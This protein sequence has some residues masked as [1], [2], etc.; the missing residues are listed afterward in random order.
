M[1][2]TNLIINDKPVLP[3]A[4]CH[5]D[6][7]IEQ[8]AGVGYFNRLNNIVLLPASF[9]AAIG[10]YLLQRGW[11]AGDNVFELVTAFMRQVQ[12]QSEHPGLAEF[13]SADN[14]LISSLSYGLK[15]RGYT[16]PTLQLLGPAAT[17]YLIYP[18]IA[19]LL[20]HDIPQSEPRELTLNLARLLAGCCEEPFERGEKSAAAANLTWQ[21][22]QGENN[23]VSQ[24]AGYELSLGLPATRPLFG[25]NT[26]QQLYRLPEF[27]SAVFIADPQDSAMAFCPALTTDNTTQI[28]GNRSSTA[29]YLRVEAQQNRVIYAISTT[30]NALS[31]NTDP[32]SVPAVALP[33]S[34]PNDVL[35]F[36]EKALTIPQAKISLW[37]SVLR[38]PLRFPEVASTILEEDIPPWSA[39]GPR[40]VIHDGALA[41]IMHRDS[42]KPVGRPDSNLN[43][44]LF[45]PSSLSAEEELYQMNVLDSEGLPYPLFAPA[46]SAIDC[47]DCLPAPAEPVS[48]S[49]MQEMIGK[50]F[51]WVNELG[52]KKKMQVIEQ[53]MHAKRLFNPQENAEV[54]RTELENIAAASEWL[55]SCDAMSNTLSILGAEA[56]IFLSKLFVAS[57]FDQ[58]EEL[59]KALIASSVAEVMLAK[60]LLTLLDRHLPSTKQLLKTSNQHMTVLMNQAHS[61]TYGQLDGFLTMLQDS[62]ISR[63]SQSLRGRFSTLPD[64]I[65][66]HRM[67]GMA[68]WHQRMIEFDYPF[69]LLRHKLE[70]RNETCLSPQGLLIDMGIRRVANRDNIASVSRKK[71]IELG[72]DLLLH[73]SADSLVGD[74]NHLEG[75]FLA[76]EGNDG[77][78]IRYTADHLKR[79]GVL[80][81]RFIAARRQLSALVKLSASHDA[82]NAK[83]FKDFCLIKQ[84]L[85]ALAFESLLRSKQQALLLNLQGING[86]ELQFVRLS[87]TEN[88]AGQTRPYIGFLLSS[89]GYA[90]NESAPPVMENYFI[91]LVPVQNDN[92]QP[93][94][95]SLDADLP[96]SLAERETV[97]NGKRKAEMLGRLSETMLANPSRYQFHLLNGGNLH[98]SKESVLW[99][100][101]VNSLAREIVRRQFEAI[102]PAEIQ[103]STTPINLPQKT[104]QQ[105]SSWFHNL[106][107]QLIYLT[108]L[109]SCKDAINDI[110]QGHLAPLILDAA[111]CFYAFAPGG[112][113]EEEAVKSVANVIKKVLKSALDDRKIVTEGERVLSHLD[114]SIVEAEQQLE[115]R[116]EKQRPVHYHYTPNVDLSALLTVAKQ[117][118]AIPLKKLPKDYQIVTA[119]RDPL[120]DVFYFT[121]THNSEE[122]L[123]YRLDEKNQLLM[124]NL[125]GFLLAWGQSEEHIS[126]LELLKSCLESGN[127]QPLRLKI[128]KQERIGQLMKYAFESRS[129][130]NSIFTALT[131]SIKDGVVYYPGIKQEE[132]EALYLVAPAGLP[133]DQ[134]LVV[135]ARN[136]G[137]HF[138]KDNVIS[139]KPEISTGIITQ[140]TDAYDTLLNSLTNI[141]TGWT[142]K[143]L[144]IEENSADRIVVS[145]ED[146]QGKTHYR[147]PDSQGKWLFWDSKHRDIFCQVLSRPKR[148]DP[149]NSDLVTEIFSPAQC[150]YLL[151]P[152]VD[153]EERAEAL[154]QL[155]TTFMSLANPVVLDKIDCSALAQKIYAE[156]NPI[157]ET[158]PKIIRDFIINVR[159]WNINVRVFNIFEVITRALLDYSNGIIISE[160]LNED[161]KSLRSRFVAHVQNLIEE[162]G[163]LKKAVITSKLLLEEFKAVK[164]QYLEAYIYRNLKANNW[165]NRRFAGEL[166]SG[167]IKGDYKIK[168][169]T[170]A[171]IRRD[172][173]FLHENV[174]AALSRLKEMSS[175][176]ASQLNST[177]SVDFLTSGL[178]QFF[179]AGFTPVQIENFK[180][181]LQ[182][183]LTKLSSFNISDI[184]V[185]A[186]RIAEG[187]LISGCFK[188]PLEKLVFGDGAYSF[189]YNSDNDKRIYLLDYLTDQKFLEFSLAH[190][191]VHLTYED[192]DYVFQEEIYLLSESILKNFNMPGA[193]KFAGQLMSNK[194]FF[195]DY[196]SRN[197]KYATAFYLHFYAQSR[198]HIHKKELLRHQEYF[199]GRESIISIGNEPR[200]LIKKRLAPLVDYLF[201]EPYIKLNMAYYNP[202]L[203]CGLFNAIY[204]NA[205]GTTQHTASG[206][207]RRETNQYHGKFVSSYM[208]LLFSALY[209]KHL[210]HPD[211]GLAVE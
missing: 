159:D 24:P 116:L 33:S 105:P 64:F 133:E 20:H 29:F 184:V 195:L 97:I 16:L 2:L 37:S 53:F 58:N 167:K 118:K 156:F 132:G 77:R 202:D 50:A 94:I 36:P 25:P 201:S 188:T 115:A 103:Q 43:A 9:T 49:S 55:T 165:L 41:L 147:H 210:M 211:A 157:W 143:N 107:N 148:N 15:Q 93:L 151:V 204:E 61:V 3:V 153:S 80:L 8:A 72:H 48:A 142:M 125:S 100:Q 38:D 140:A 134:Q 76:A 182:L 208:S 87:D 144:W 205:I 169:A 117:F 126:D 203:F 73:N 69:M 26:S 179:N 141:P 114:S 89:A 166:R 209:H 108:P 186:D 104:S 112:S 44:Q 71:L 12:T 150:G 46:D 35:R 1:P 109:G 57:P 7:L 82:S 11:Q 185:V 154:E 10:S 146:S 176:I 74:F 131:V 47:L 178:N 79:Q 152:R 17:F 28:I 81:I 32:R 172:Y 190:E 158:T 56:N 194:A 18:L 52:L 4:G 70:L 122:L 68:C 145:W 197:A 196:I 54:K 200:S 62:F 199:L 121:F 170:P 34:F 183:F 23:G 91:S 123:V 95:F 171:K 110:E 27:S 75:L 111:F 161:D 30:N 113:E 193:T 189:V 98:A 130:I 128:Y 13:A 174:T 192:I 149:P 173:P 99:P 31:I 138:W 22:Q 139:F 160:E 83:A 137:I 90:D 102:N 120:H 119:W 163:K 63:L 66:T 19:R 187:K 164:K 59:K 84:Q 78:G 5:N 136:K 92:T 88:G 67:A 135:V 191:L 162:Y 180:V 51:V 155:K 85:Y 96:K 101:V 45:K 177:T 60:V 181:K 129:D 198:N 6:N 168:A 124:P 21:S 86:V 206:R 39:R 207:I 106:V 175:E 127:M 42:K 40:G 14:P 65:T